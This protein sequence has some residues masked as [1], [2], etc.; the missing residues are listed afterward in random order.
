MKKAIAIVLGL[1]LI[2]SLTTV[3]AYSANK[4]KIVRLC[5]KDTTT[6]QCQ[7]GIKGWELTDQGGR[8][9]VK[10]YNGYVRYQEQGE[11]LNLFLSTNG[12]D[13][14][15]EYQVALVGQGGTPTDNL[16]ANACPNPNQGFPWVC[17]YWGN[18]GF[19]NF[20]IGTLGDIRKTRNLMYD[21]FNVALPAGEYTGVKFLV[22]QNEAPWATYLFETE[23]LNFEIKGTYT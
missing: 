17:G 1:L 9:P 8:R 5:E 19:Y 22:K 15:R 18:Q 12:L 16:L 7:K 21:A 11:M 13:Q 14:E 20:Y 10:Y 3:M 2:L 6:W 23:A 4:K